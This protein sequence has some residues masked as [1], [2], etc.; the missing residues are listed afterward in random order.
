MRPAV[1]S[2][3]VV[4]LCTGA[5]P[6]SENQILRREIARMYPGAL[7]MPELADRLHQRGISMVTGDV[8]L[9]RVRAGEL[10]ASD[11]W[12]I[13]EDRSPE[14]EE[15]ISLGAKGRVLLCFES[16]LFAASFYRSLSRISRSFDHCVV[17]QGAL[18][19]ASPLVKA[20][21]LYFPSFDENQRCADQ[22]WSARK[23]LVMVAG[24][25]Y[26]KIRRSPIRQMFAKI[27][28]LALR[29]P[30][31]FASEHASAQLHDE[32]LAA[33]SHFGR[34]GRLDLY[35]SGWGNLNNLPSHWQIELAA[36]VPSLNPAPCADKLATMAN[37]KFALCF[38]NLEF[39]GYVTEK[40]ID[41]LL[42]GV[43]PIY[44]GA[45]DIRDFIP[46]NCFIDGRK[47]SS[48]DLLDVHLGKISEVE[49]VEIL[50]YGRAFLQSI[51]G[52]RYSY[53]GFADRVEA[54]LID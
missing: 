47:F 32:R 52:Q 49:W 54:M 10:Q 16:P 19:D 7:W 35:G 14:A 22:P 29:S 39:P 11:T 15:L 1:I 41:C 45:P 5:A 37:Y 38:E 44:R 4:A 50:S 43:V 27:R 21:K 40:V 3:R 6:F 12:V 51:A 36:T 17:F 2:T 42:A 20:H 28:D 30:E 31:R 34:A 46:E 53:K 26:W 48:L 9:R 13:E 18:K 33:I 25:K 23:Y 24:N 8:A